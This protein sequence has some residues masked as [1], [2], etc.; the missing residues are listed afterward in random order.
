MAR[1]KDFKTI[2]AKLLPLAVGQSVEVNDI[3]Y[4]DSADQTAKQGAASN[5]TLLRVGTFDQK[6]DNSAGSA[7]ILTN[8]TFEREVVATWIPSVTGANAVTSGNLFGDCYVAGNN[9][10]TK[11]SSGNSKAGR[12]WAVDSVLGALVESYTL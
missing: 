1:M 5:A 8:V 7:P 10:V 4:V 12:V 2:K 6:V 9:L 3:A 11:S